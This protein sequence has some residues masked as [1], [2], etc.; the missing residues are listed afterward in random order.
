MKNLKI[1]YLI[2][3]ANFNSSFGAKIFRQV[4]D[5]KC[6]A[7]LEYFSAS[8]S[9]REPWALSCK[10]G[11]ALVENSIFNFSF[12]VFDSWTKFQ[13]GVLHG[14]RVDFGNF[15]QCLDFKFDSTDSRVGLIQGQHCLIYYRA[16]PNATTAR[17]PD[18]KFDWSEM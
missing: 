5:T 1:L 18:G 15:E 6:E 8:L 17:E 10:S 3:I 9:K 7:Q 2:L 11:K 4:D 12:S 13:S 16:T 14:N